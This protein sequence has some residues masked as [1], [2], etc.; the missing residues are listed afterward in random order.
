MRYLLRPDTGKF[1]LVYESPRGNVIRRE[2]FL[3]RALQE[4]SELNQQ[5]GSGWTRARESERIRRRYIE[6]EE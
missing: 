3:E 5:C 4:A 2:L 1:W 6:S